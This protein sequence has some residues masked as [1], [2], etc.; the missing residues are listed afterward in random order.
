MDRE[1]H[2]KLV[3][4]LYRVTDLFPQDPLKFKIRERATDILAG[5]FCSEQESP[6]GKK[7]LLKDIKV[8]VGFLDLARTQ[9]WVDERNFLAL[10]REYDNIRNEI[11]S[12]RIEAKPEMAKPAAKFAYSSNAVIPSS[13]PRQGKILEI[14]KQ[15]PNWQVGELQAF[16]AGTSKRTL[17]RDLDNLLRQNKIKRKGEWNLVSYELVSQV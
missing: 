7:S 6:A 8:L 17:R 1:Y 14:F 16:F 4:G 15:K 12:S 9:N 2:I 3:S 5:L 11:E 10:K 13:S